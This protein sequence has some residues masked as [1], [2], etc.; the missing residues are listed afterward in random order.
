MAHVMT[1]IQ[2]LLGM[3]SRTITVG[4]ALW[5]A[6]ATLLCASAAT[7]SASHSHAEQ[8]DPAVEFAAKPLP[9]SAV[10]LT[11]GPL[12][13]AQELNAKYLLELE[14][15]RMLA[16]YRVRAGLEPKAEG[17][18]GWDDVN[19]RQLTG[20]IAGHYLSAVALMYAATGDERFKERAD[21]I[22]DELKVVQ[23]KNGDGYLGALLGTRPGAARRNGPPSP[24]D[25]AD[26]REL[27]KLL[28]EGEIRSGGF[29]LNGMWSPWYTL[30]KTYAGL[31]DA[32]RC[33]GN[34]TA[35]ELEVKFAEWCERVLAPL[36][37]EQIQQMLNTEFGGMNEIL[38]DLYADTGDERW[39]KL[40]YKFEHH[41]FIEPL[42]QGRDHLAGKHGNTQ[43]PKLIGS[44]ARYTYTGSESDLDAATFFWE[45][46]GEHHSFATGG[47]GKDEYFGPADKLSEFIYG[48]TA[49]TCNVY[50]MLKLTRTLFAVNPEARYAEFQERALFNHIL[51]SID[52]IDGSTC[53]MVPVGQGVEREYADMF[54]SFTCCV[55]S[56][57][58]SHALHG[59]GV[60]YAAPKQ[61]WITQ[62][63]PSTADWTDAGVKIS[64]ETEFPLAD[65]AT[66]NIDAADSKEFTLTL[67]RPAWAGDGFRIDVNDETVDE[68]PEPGSL[69]AIKR[70]W[71]S[72]DKVTITL[73]KTL[74][75]EPLPGNDRRA[76]IMWGPLVMAGDLES[77]QEEGRR[78]RRGDE[79]RR[80]GD[81]G[82]GTG[83][84]A[85]ILTAAELPIADW[86]EP[87]DDS[88][89]AFRTNGV[90]RNRDVPLEPFYRLHRK[91]YMAYFD[92][93]TP[94]EWAV[95]SAE[96]AADRIRQRQLELATV[97]YAQPG[98]M[99]PERDFNYQGDD[100]TPIRVDG[101][102][103][104][105]GQG[106]FS[107]DM[108]VDASSPLALVA[109]YHT[110]DWRRRTPSEFAISIDGEP[111]ADVQVEASSPPTFLDV[112]YPLN[113]NLV[114]G[115]EK[116]TVRFDAK[117]Q[118]QIGPVFGV[119]IVRKRSEDE[120]RVTAPPETFFAMVDEG[121]RDAARHFYSKYVEVNGMPIVASGEVDDNA[122]FRT[123][124]IVEHMLAGRPDITQ[125]LVD[126]EMY[127]IIIGKDQLYC[128][129]PEYRN[130]PNPSYQNERVRGTGG[131]PTSFGEENLLSLAL[132]RYD[133]E[134]IAVH[135]FCHTIDGALGTIDPTWQDRKRA[136][137][138][139]ALEKGLY[140]LAYAAS[141]AGEYWAEIGQAYF[142]CNR[143][144][145]W[146]HGPIGNR[147]QLRAYDPVGYELARS[148]FNLSPEQ[149][150]RYTYL[151]KHPI[152]MAPPEKFG[153][154]S[155]YAKFSFARELP[156]LA[157]GANDAAILKANDTIRKMF[158]YRHDI[159][160]AFIADGMKVVVL[161]AGES[162]ANLPEL[163]SEAGSNVDLLA[164]VLDYSPDAKLIAVGQ[165]NVMAN[166]AA[167]GVGG[168]EL[169]RALAKAIY[170][171]TAKRPVDPKW[172]DR[173]YAVQQYELRVERLDE[174]FDKRLQELYA[175]AMEQKKWQGTSGVNSHVDYWAAGVT[176]YFDA[177]GQDAAPNDAPHPIATREALRDYD[178]DLFT[179][180]NEVMAYDGRVDWRYEAAQLE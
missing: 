69:V 34:Q 162:L 166:P 180:V 114:A 126:R 140:K 122:L 44:L 125:A 55:G 168:S 111:L 65:S 96:V 161:G 142:D 78:G 6:V 58:E 115:K 79:R 147:E 11:G 152:V 141:N 15:D 81:H 50:N 47:H 138:Q 5:H 60:Y 105:V 121:D 74:R 64:I 159:V 173:G 73:P 49:E 132:D 119:R 176:A 157:H 20:H 95:K 31:R 52:P 106:W 103:G 154:D 57:M 85:P 45:R 19:G 82:R 88:V 101:R 160:K 8:I 76:A 108:P 25:L 133:D 131:R 27:F 109:T 127:L 54:R 86:V 93:Y 148:V 37:D 124:T 66:I 99:Q 63:I 169:I 4:R 33:A 134:S 91:R 102:A 21:Y 164:R 40:S 151:Q 174:R 153:F 16:G 139:N 12:K 179:L 118:R 13:H 97:G 128:E 144:N 146:N 38:A 32:Y 77:Q 14:P 116:V 42:K 120:A 83:Q 112:E 84:D 129:M 61:L 80:R 94:E 10:R 130:H 23:D 72:G 2:G 22:V 110:G 90:G 18:G 9:L 145:N 155:Y 107:F 71:K 156:V 104:R 26:G 92:L 123:R 177:A 70:N 29:D 35:L 62:Y 170:R 171:V 68:L 89:G 172:N 53:Y 41:D 7:V 67:R 1:L 178:P 75:L 30:H 28:S 39:L 136:A 167:P 175:T 113:E 24:D 87:V 143:V 46:V 165:E 135:E 100:A 3:T 158:A 98:E 137:Y 163:N 117:P 59:D 48:R 56:G 43:V 51:A 150:W 36:S 17:Y 149:D